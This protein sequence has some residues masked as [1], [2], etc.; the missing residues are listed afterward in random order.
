MRP[1]WVLAAVLAA[2]LILPAA[3]QSQP[4]PS[5]VKV[6]P[7]VGSLTVEWAVA[8]NE[9]EVFGWH[10]KDRPD[11]EP[12]STWGGTVELP[13]T[14]RSHTFSGLE[15]REYEI[16]ITTVLGVGKLGPSKIVTGTPLAKEESFATWRGYTAFNPMAAATV[17][18]AA[19]A[20]INQRVPANPV[21][22][23]NSKAMVELV[24]QPQDLWTDGG[25]DHPWYYAKESD[26]LYEITS[27]ASGGS[28]A[29][30]LKIHIPEAAKAAP[31]TDGHMGVVEKNGEMFDFW[32]VGDSGYA[33][34][35]NG[36]LEA[37]GAGYVSNF[38]TGSGVSEREGSSTASGFNIATGVIRPEELAAGEIKH[39]LF[40][41]VHETRSGCVL[42]PAKSS[43]G[44]SG[45]VNS[46][47]QGQR[48]YLA[49]TDAEIAALPDRWER[50]IATAAAHY[51]LWVG[52][53]GGSGF[54]LKLE[55]AQ[56]R[57]A[58][59][60]PNPFNE[61]VK[62]EPGVKGPFTG[63]GGTAYVLPLKE[64]IDWTRLRAIAFP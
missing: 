18:F 5:E 19:E 53:S 33:G 10:L 47:C 51:G 55:G 17:P 54:S 24:G 45:N 1:R 15:V 35:A 11:T 58:Y 20:F 34:P 56:D 32:D 61:L 2:L 64:G 12:A 36:K 57:M 23:S 40:M 38:A 41:P 13:P 27:V 3:A 9:A 28:W 44:T 42:A 49:Y 39:G 4:A 22:L 31:G 29:N 48:F 7:G 52:D 16:K 30:G 25:Y 6:T 63:L 43:D 14:P 21:V 37:G 8:G 62:G 50:T 59:G 46:P 26:P 60:L